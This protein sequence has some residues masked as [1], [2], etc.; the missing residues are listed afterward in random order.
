MWSKSRSRISACCGIRCGNYT[1]TSSRRDPRPA[2]TAKS[3]RSRPPPTSSSTVP[4]SSAASAAGSPSCPATSSIQEPRGALASS[5]RGCG[6]S[7]DREYRRAAESGAVTTRPPVPVATRDPPQRRSRAEA[8]H[9]RPHLRL[10]RNHQPRQRLGHPA[11]RRRHL[12]RNPGEHSE[13]LPGGC[14]RSRN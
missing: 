12:Y 5:P 13:A 4:Q 9:R 3:C 11:P 1:P 2:S 6:R 8:D 7:R 14:G 10:S